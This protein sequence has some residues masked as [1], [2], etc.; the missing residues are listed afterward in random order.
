LH[1]ALVTQHGGRLSD[2]SMRRRLRATCECA[3]SVGLPIERL[4]VL[5]KQEWRDTPAARRLR[6]MEATS[7][8]ERIVTLCIDE[9]YA[10]PA[11]H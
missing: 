10:D 5:L 4:L 11:S 1:E 7:V 9:F 3:R 8:L 6:R 2:D